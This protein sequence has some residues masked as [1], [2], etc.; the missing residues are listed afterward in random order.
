MVRAVHDQGITQL[1]IPGGQLVFYTVAAGFI[2]V[3]AAIG[4]ARRASRLDVLAAIATE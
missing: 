4:P 3:I 2:G 1:R